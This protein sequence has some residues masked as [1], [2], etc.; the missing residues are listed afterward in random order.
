[1][2]LPGPGVGRTHVAPAPGN[3]AVRLGAIV[4]FAKTSRILAELAGGTPTA[5]GTSACLS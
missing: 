3:F 1:M 5:P 4:R 2:R